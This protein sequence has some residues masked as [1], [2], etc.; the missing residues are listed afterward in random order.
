MNDIAKWYKPWF[1]V[2][3]HDIFKATEV[4]KK[5]VEYLPLRDYYHRHSR[6]LFWEIQVSGRFVMQ[7]RHLNDDS[8]DWLFRFRIL[9]RSETMLSSAISSA[10]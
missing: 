9:C 2:H 4:G 10:G 5:Y 7:T 6:A 1:F 8:F 3:V